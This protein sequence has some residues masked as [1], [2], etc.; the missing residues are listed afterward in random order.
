MPDID[1]DSPRGVPMSE[2]LLAPVSTDVELCYQTFGDPSGDPLLLVMGLS[3]PMT[4]WDAD[5]CRMLAD[6][7]FF[8]ARFDNRDIG[9]STKMRGRVKRSRVVA[10]FLGRPVHAPYSL[11]DMARDAFGLM[12]H[13]GWR[14]SHVVGVSMGG[15]IAQTMALSEPHRICSLTSMSSTTGRR[16]VGWQHPR[17]L[18]LLTTNRGAGRQSYIDNSVSIWRHL[19]SPAYRDDEQVMRD[20]AADTYDRGWWAG[21]ALRQMMAVLTQPD[22]SRTLRSLRMP[23]LVVHGL[24]DSMVHVSGGRATASAIHGAELLL[25]EGMG[26]D[27]PKPLWETFVEAIRRT[28]DRV[29][30]SADRC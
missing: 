30:V 20:R 13:L 19:E 11:A 26:H 9:R 1:S 22:R 6:Q 8:V 28:A 25:V 3:G 23:A 7:G 14:S 2:E 29:S 17:L 24:A 5:F 10:A 27:L 18:P 12:D 4:W 15:M 21:G 16:T